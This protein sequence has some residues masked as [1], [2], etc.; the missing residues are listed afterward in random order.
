[1][2]LVSIEDKLA[3]IDIDQRIFSVKTFIN[4]F[5]KILI[6]SENIQFLLKNMNFKVLTL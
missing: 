3:D 5:R 4:D 1:M 2:N 6:T